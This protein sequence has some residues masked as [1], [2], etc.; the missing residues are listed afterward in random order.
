[1]NL[2]TLVIHIWGDTIL[3]NMNLHSCEC[4]YICRR[5]GAINPEIAIIKTREMLFDLNQIDMLMKILQMNR[6]FNIV[7]I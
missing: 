2:I 6:S 1:M 7:F 4:K 5:Q 3:L